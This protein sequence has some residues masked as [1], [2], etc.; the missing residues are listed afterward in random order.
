[1]EDLGNPV[2]F[3]W[4]LPFHP[5]DPHAEASG[6]GSDSDND[7]PR[8]NDDECSPETAGMEFVNLLVM[9]KRTG[10]RVT[11]TQVC[12]LCYWAAK[13]EI[14]GPASELALHPKS[15]TQNFS[16]KFDAFVG[17]PDDEE[18]YRI[19]VPSYRRADARRSTLSLPAFPAH[20]ILVEE[21]AREPK[22]L[23]KL[24]DDL[25]NMPPCY[26]RHALVAE[27]PRATVIPTSVYVDGTAFSENDN[28]IAFYF[29]NW[30]T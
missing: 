22:M 27:S 29:V 7:A 23:Q 8:V 12:Q 21:L 10:T 28:L 18:H 30:I 11:A 25:D 4:E 6:E 2:P 9:L 3:S 26:A 5:E 17:N 19:D 13:A 15:H 24:A 20:E 16:R 14:K 1:M